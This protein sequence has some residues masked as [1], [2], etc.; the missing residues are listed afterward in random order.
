MQPIRRLQR[1]RHLKGLPHGRGFGSEFPQDKRIAGGMAGKRG[2]ETHIIRGIKALEQHFGNIDLDPQFGH[3]MQPHDRRARRDRAEIGDLAAG[4]EGVKRG[5]QRGMS[6]AVGRITQSQGS[7]L[8][9][10]FG[11][12]E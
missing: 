8:C 3:V 2:M 4:H 6:M 11:L 9:L 7:K 10:R 12:F 5:L 1:K